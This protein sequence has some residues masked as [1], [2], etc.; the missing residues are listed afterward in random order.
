M[1]EHHAKDL[2]CQAVGYLVCPLA[3]AV[4]CSPG[5]GRP[6]GAFWGICDAT[7]PYG[8]HFPLDWSAHDAFEA[9]QFPGTTSKMFLSLLA[10]WGI[11]GW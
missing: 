5:A 8:C 1:R 6:G 11:G 4:Q 10:R 9:P 2:G 7:T 3:P